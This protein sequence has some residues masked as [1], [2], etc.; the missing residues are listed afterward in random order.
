MKTLYLLRHAKSDWSNP[1]RPD[2]D[3]PLNRRGKRTRKAIARYV[4][5]WPLDLVV[6][7]TARRARATAK[8]I[9]ESLRCEVRYEPSVYASSAAEL[10]D[11]VRNAPDGA[12]SVMLVGHNPGL[13]DLAAM[14]C[15]SPARFPTAALGTIELR[16]D[17][18]RDAAPRTGTLAALVTP[19]DLRAQS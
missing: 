10:L 13:E 4:K 14:V 11:V 15:G 7:S 2:H 6:C 16:I 12:R 1:T 3:R 18:W 9:V 8:P 5:G 19:A 17:H